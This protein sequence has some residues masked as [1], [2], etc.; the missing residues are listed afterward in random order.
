MFL[1]ERLFGFGSYM[2]VL[3]LV[4]LFLGRTN[5][6]CKLILNIYLVCLCTMAFLYKPYVTA[7]LYKIYE[8]MDFF[9]T[10]EFRI[11]WQ[12][13]V[14]GS[15]MPV[16]RLL[17][18]TIGKTG[19]NT[20]LP[21][22]SCF[23]CYSS[24]FYIISRTQKLYDVSNRTVAY[25]LFF[26]MT[27]SIYISVIGGIRMMMSLCMIA[28]SYFRGSVERKVNV[29]DIL[30]YVLAVFLHAMGAVV[31]AVCI[32]VALFD[33]DRNVL[34]KIGFAIVAAVVGLI[35][36][37]NFTDTMRGLNEKFLEYVLGDRYSDPW[38]YAMG[39]LII[40]LLLVLF[41]E[42]RRTCRD[43]DGLSVKKYN[44]S[45]IWCVVIALCFHFEFSIFYRFG[46]QLAVL[47]AMPTLMLTLEKNEGEAS[48][49]IRGVDFRSVLMIFSCVIAALSCTRGS[50]SSLK[51]FE[52]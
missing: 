35:F 30:L 46:G 18:W 27:S 13:Y 12:D 37:F 10:M 17:Y 50:L 8:Q 31:I 1:F 41:V 7:D 33:S 43:E 19:V 36:V 39:V 29:F 14:V 23:V 5:V 28:Y 3:L 21:V 40:A 52:L 47:L 48:S 9:S 15:S 25:V 2:L 24:T 20:L 32:V 34:R 26:V 42:F 16:A 44:T 49:V 38:E 51:F 6:S 4:C 11:F 22:L 45:A